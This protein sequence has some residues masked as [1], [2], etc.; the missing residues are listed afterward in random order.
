MRPAA[1][2]RII[3]LGLLVVLLFILVP[4]ALHVPDNL[5]LQLDA[6]QPAEP[7]I[8]W[9]LL[10]PPVS[11]SEQHDISSQISQQRDALVASRDDKDNRLRAY[12]LK[13]ASYS[14][15][16][17]AEKMRQSLNDAGFP[18]YVR[19]EDTAGKVAFTLYAGPKLQKTRLEQL[20]NH[21]RESRQ[22]DF[23]NVTTVFYQP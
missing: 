4:W 22:F 20:A 12:A 8:D 16:A 5:Q 2:Q 3:G 1:R 21:L 11:S 19:D 23:P 15:R 7:M 9:K 17:A 6:G 14:S 18:A 10:Q 13:L